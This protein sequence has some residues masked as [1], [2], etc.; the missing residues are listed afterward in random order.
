MSGEN[1]FIQK[2]ADVCN[3]HSYS[4]VVLLTDSTLDGLYNFYIKEIAEQITLPF[5]KLVVPAGEEAKSLSQVEKICKELLDLECDKD[6]CLLNFGGGVICDLGGFVASVY[7]RGID[8]INYPTT[9]ISMLDAAIGGKTGVNLSYAKNAVGL[10]H[11]PLAVI[12]EDSRF[13]NT[14][15]QEELLSGFGEMIKYA[16][17]GLPTLFES[18][19]ALDQMTASNIDS[20]WIGQCA[21]FKRQVV[22]VDPDD[23]SYRHILNFGHTIGHAIESCFMEF[24]MPIPHGVA[25][26]EGMYYESLLSCQFGKLPA[27]ELRQI[28]T[29][30]RRHFPALSLKKY[31]DVLIRYVRQ[32]KKNRSEEI[33]F[34]L[35]DSIGHARHDGLLSRKLC[36]EFLMHSLV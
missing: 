22:E 24:G 4:A 36:A 9:L 21:E 6:T 31:E 16:L 14:L 5:H 19:M 33:N 8:F 32:D 34:T 13:L 17:I 26:A 27:E 28:H 1:I 29:L 3:H 15:S 35:L 30:I 18:L 25:V 10:I 11:Q 2:L 7:K 12:G 20:S 23:K